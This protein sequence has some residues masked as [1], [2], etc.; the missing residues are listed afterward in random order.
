MADA[1]LVCLALFRMSKLKYEN[2]HTDSKTVIFIRANLGKE[3]TMKTTV[4]KSI[5]AHSI[6]QVGYPIPILWSGSNS[7][8]AHVILTFSE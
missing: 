7:G 8:H 5:Y 2:V 3:E 6:F 4:L 1:Y